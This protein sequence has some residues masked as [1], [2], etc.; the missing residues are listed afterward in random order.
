[1]NRENFVSAVPYEGKPSGCL[2][3]TLKSIFILINILLVLENIQ[4]GIACYFLIKFYQQDPRDFDRVL[5]ESKPFIMKTIILIL[6]RSAVNIF[7][8]LTGF[9]GI[10]KLS[11]PSLY[12]FNGL[13][14]LNLISVGV[15]L[16]M[17]SG[18]V[19]FAIAD[20]ALGI[21][22]IPLS[23]KIIAMIKDKRLF[24]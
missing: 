11:L 9:I 12:I 20:L 6:I 16:F 18:T 7:Q 14:V 5:E 15:M 22:I 2:W 13:T 17:R 21:L 4:M 1:M 10:F 24:V 8:W 23:Y 3:I 19:I